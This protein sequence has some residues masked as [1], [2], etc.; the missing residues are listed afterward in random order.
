MPC[1]KGM[2][3]TLHFIW[4]IYIFTKSNHFSSG[5]NVNELELSPNYAGTLKGA[6]GT[7]S[8]VCGFLTPALA[9]YL[10]DGQQTLEVWSTVFQ[11]SA[12]VY[13]FGTLVFVLFGRTSVQPWNTYWNAEV[14]DK[15]EEIPALINSDEVWKV[16][17]F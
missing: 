6:T 7:I 13:V 10:T 16:T 17:L 11:I 14:N 12:T 4:L 2:I 1:Q 8:N 5:F 9:G 3:C 15:S